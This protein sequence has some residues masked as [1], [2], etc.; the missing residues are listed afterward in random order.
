MRYR[1]PSESI[2][3]AFDVDSN[4]RDKLLIDATGE[5]SVK[6][7]AELRAAFEIILL[8]CKAP[9]I[10]NPI[11]RITIESSIKENAV[12]FLSFINNLGSRQL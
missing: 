10:N 8:P 2:K 11:T 3:L 5:L 1:S 6:V 7:L 4:Q 12:I 9:A